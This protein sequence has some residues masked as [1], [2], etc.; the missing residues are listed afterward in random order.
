MRDFEKLLVLG[1]P[2]GSLL[3]GCRHDATLFAIPVVAFAV[4]VVLED[5]AVRQNV[6][7]RAWPSEGFADFALGTNV[8]FAG[9]NLMVSA[10]LFFVGSAAA[11]AAGF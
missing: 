11:S 10:L 3:L 8:A 9:W 5:R 2:V 1:N 7:T 6:G 4:Y